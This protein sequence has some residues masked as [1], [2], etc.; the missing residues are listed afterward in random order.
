MQIIFTFETQYGLFCDALNLP[1]DHQFSNEELEIMK[2][3]RLN[4]WVDVVT[5]SPDTTSIEDTKQFRLNNKIA[6]LKNN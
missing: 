1:D 4:N 3:Q 5:T 2:Q 6:I